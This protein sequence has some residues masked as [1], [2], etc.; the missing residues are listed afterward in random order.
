MK[1]MPKQKNQFYSVI[2]ETVPE[3]GY[4]AFVPELPGC[5]SQGD[6]L[7]ETKRNIKEAVEVYLES[8]EK[9]GTNLPKRDILLGSVEVAL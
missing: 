8:L 4:L 6:N 2:Y 7:A 9:K 3:G 1:R 5:H